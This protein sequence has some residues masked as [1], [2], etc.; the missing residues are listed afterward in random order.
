MM[1]NVA[2][3]LAVYAF[4]GLVCFLACWM[5]IRLIPPDFLG[6]KQSPRSNHSGSPRQLGGI[7]LLVTTFLT[8]SLGMV[9]S[10]AVNPPNPF[11]VTALLLAFLLGLLDD[12]R[13]LEV[14]TR[15]LAQTLIA[16]MMV[17]A[18]NWPILDFSYQSAFLMVLAVIA[19]VYWVNAVNFMDGLDWLLV[20]GMMPALVLHSILLVHIS[21]DAEYE[22]AILVLAC[23]GSL[24]GFAVWNRP[25]AKIFMGDSGS[26]FLGAVS[27][28]S[29][30]AISE[31]LGLLIAIT[32]FL[33]FIIDTS[34]TI[35]MRLFAGENIF[36][37]HSAHAYQI[38]YRKGVTAGW[39]AFEVTMLN[40]WLVLLAVMMIDV[41]FFPQ[42]ALF[43]IG[44]LTTA[45]FTSKLRRCLN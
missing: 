15:F 22:L 38:A 35:V 16:M 2:D 17:H 41:K 26:L 9:F 44:C 43:L 14:R 10:H 25:P 7:A 4:A 42:L 6:V 34:T 37:A 11:M 1:Q 3:F 27:V 21:P 29:I 23:A 18:T 20:A 40:L 36:K 32:P 30:L 24:A 31:K 28:A 33:Y 45:L 39:I 8:L 12:H 5:A 13:G 19:S